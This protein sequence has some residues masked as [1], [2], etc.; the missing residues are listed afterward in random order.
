MRFELGSGGTG[1]LGGLGGSGATGR[2]GGSSRPDEILVLAGPRCADGVDNDLDG[3]FDSDDPDCDEPSPCPGD[4][5]DDG[6]VSVDELVL[7]NGIAAG[8]RRL[9]ECPAADVDGDGVVDAGELGSVAAAL[10]T[11][12]SR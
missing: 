7:S 8:S 1:G 6:V 2:N 12:C 10:H 11:G 4:C 5:S 3:L 9:L